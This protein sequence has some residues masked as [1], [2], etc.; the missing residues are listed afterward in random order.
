MEQERKFTIADFIA[1]VR[2]DGT[3]QLPP[4]VLEV[5]GINPGQSIH[6]EIDEKGEVTVNAY[7][8]SKKSAGEV[9]APEPIIGEQIEQ[10]PLFD[11]EPGTTKRKHKSQR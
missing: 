2:E 10:V 1:T 5:L 3:I 8:S 4:Q 6:F 7:K 11:M 9:I